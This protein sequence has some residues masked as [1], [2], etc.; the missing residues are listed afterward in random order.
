MGACNEWVLKLADKMDYHTVMWSWAYY[1]YDVNNQPEPTAALARVTGAAHG[2]GIF[3]LHA[4][5]KTN[6]EILGSV[7]DDF[8]SK[9]FTVAKY[10]AG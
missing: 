2:G 7:I 8:R 6:T 1:D 3:L 9:G 10:S 5:S 4:V